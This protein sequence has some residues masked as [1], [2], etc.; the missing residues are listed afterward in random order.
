M[1]YMSV[2]KADIAN[3][4]GWR[5][6]LWVSGCH[7]K[8]KGCF[9]PDAWCPLAGKKFDE[10]VRQKIFAE[11][12]K[13]YCSGLTL[14]GGEPMFRTNRKEVISLCRECKMKFPEKNIWMYSGFTFDQIALSPE[15][16]PV[17]GWIDVLVDGQFIQ[18]LKD[19]SL[20]FRGSTNQRIIDVQKTL[21]TGNISTIEFT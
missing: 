13:D 14:L 15:M 5:V 17:L 8:C 4:T 12:S 16:S 18:K 21:L 6:S 1:N 11:L 9:N 2:L 7:F 20:P 19:T 3:G 10:N